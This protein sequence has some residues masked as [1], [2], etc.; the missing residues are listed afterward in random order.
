MNRTKILFIVG[1]LLTMIV[2]ILYYINALEK[3]SYIKQGEL[4]LAKTD[5]DHN[6]VIALNGEWEFYWNQILDPTDFIHHNLSD[7]QYAY[8]PGNWL[9]DLEGNTYAKK[10]Y[11]TYRVSLKNIPKTKYF[12][13]KKANIRNSS[14]IFVNGE[15]II[16]DGIVSK[17]L[18][19]SVAGNN[20]DVVYF[21]L[22]DTTAEI[23]IQAANH[24]YIVGGIAK[25]IIF[26]HQKELSQ[27]HIRKVMFEFAMI[28]VVL[29]IG[30]FYL[31][32][33]LASKDYRKKE[34]VTLPLAL[35]CLIIGVMNSIY[36]ER[37]ITIIFPKLT[38]DLTFRFGHFMSGLSVITVW[39]VV[40][41][42]NNVFLPTKMRNFL[43]GL[44]SLF[45]VF[46]LTLPLEVYITTLNFYMILVIFIFFFIWLRIFLLF[47]KNKVPS[48]NE[49]EHS[50]LI[51]SVFSIF[52]FWFDM[53]L[54]SLGLKIDMF[55]SILT[56]AVYSIALAILLILRYTISYKKNEEL[57]I[58]LIETFST[59]DQTTKEVQRNELAF[60]Q[61][62]I[63]P[64]F[65][66]NALSS[67]ISLCYTNGE[68]AGKLLTDLSNYL[69][70]SFDLD[71]KTDFVTIENEL[72]LIE[73][74]V[75]IEKARFGDRIKV[76]YDIADDVLAL[77]I[78]P[79][80]IEP[81][82]ENAIRHGI[83]KN[84]DGGEVKLT[85]KKQHQS[86]YISVEDNGK[87]M[88]I[89]QVVRIKNGE[90][91]LNSS[92]GNGIS[93]TNVY[94]RLRNEY[95]VELNF[96]ANR[97]GTKVYFTIPV[98]ESCEEADDD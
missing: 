87:G 42:I 49:L 21:E 48:S 45:L 85:I 16:T 20:S 36:S 3:T 29:V 27:Q 96:D 63:K 5:F 44:Y 11:A 83:L 7:F 22:E 50:T 56:V 71:L 68:K 92:Q 59:L 30:F 66:F 54:Y 26:G 76:T 84:K 89:E 17:S 93:L 38:L 78:T 9:R 40:N 65:L 4:D 82:V 88:D 61:A 8:V 18:D 19:G 90:S 15:L 60:L 69:K 73:A 86:V 12:G 95:Q 77:R 33:F 58:K 91:D 37:I 51:V 94:T 24:E 64:H 70:R 2:L 81:L 46:V 79:L 14:K 6:C 23:I 28:L 39:I 13:L 1:T 35:S 57:S 47:F 10:G 97:S 74:F 55:V 32:L 67:I 98:K 62:Q 75:E 34:P 31:F 72:K 80:V 41:K 52:L 43:I 25:P 53:I